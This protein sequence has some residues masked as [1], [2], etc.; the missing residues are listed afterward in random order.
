[1]NDDKLPDD[2]LGIVEPPQKQGLF[3]WLRERFIAGMLIALPIVATFV[4]LEF[5][6]NLIDSRVVPMLPPALRPETYLDYAV[7]GF[8]LIILLLFLTL[9]GS[10]ATNFLGNY[11]V[12]LTDRVLTRVPVVRSV[13]SVFK[14]IRDVFQSNSAGQYKEV[15]MIQFPT[16]GSWAIGFVAGAVKGE[17]RHR[18]GT[19]FIGVFVPTTPNPT[20]G[21]LVYA[22]ASD[23]VKLD[24]TIEEGAKVIFSGGLVIPEYPATGKPSAPSAK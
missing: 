12:S 4:I 11:F 2:L 19:E 8:G 9:L 16:E 5:L 14:Q 13:Y 1:M 22:K 17:M 24:M 23:V 3:A 20:S 7:P 10:V 21:F 15:V 18:L 6:I